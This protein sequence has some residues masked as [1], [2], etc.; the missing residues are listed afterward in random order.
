M[1]IKDMKQSD[2]VKDLK[3]NSSTVSNWCQGIMI[4]R[5]DKLR[6]LA[7]YLGVNISDLVDD[8]D[9]TSQNKELLNKEIESLTKALNDKDIKI[10]EK[11]GAYYFK[12]R[13]HKFKI[14]LEEIKDINEKIRR[15]A[16]FE[17]NE[18]I[19]RHTNMQDIEG[20]KVRWADQEDFDNF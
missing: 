11:N 14:S 19:F 15:Y 7:E 12:N 13:K 8:K 16:K 9:S 5:M 18:I 1:E 2:I 17:I 3:I 6:L 10:F 4:P 20:N